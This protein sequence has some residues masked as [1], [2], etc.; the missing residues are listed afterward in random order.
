MKVITGIWKIN[1]AQVNGFIELCKWIEPLSAKEEGHISYTFAENKLAAGTFLF[2]E[3]WKDQAAIDFHVAQ[4]YFKEF[5]EK[6]TPLL[7]EK[8]IIKIY[9]IAGI[10]VL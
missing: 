10:T 9:D 1:P 7:S 4:P 3:E 5:M 2:F 6:T 8:P